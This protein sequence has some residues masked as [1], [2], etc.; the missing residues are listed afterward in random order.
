MKWR[1]RFRKIIKE[2]YRIDEVWYPI[3]H[4]QLYTRFSWGKRTWVEIAH[5]SMDRWKREKDYLENYFI[6]SSICNMFDKI[7]EIMND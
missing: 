3:L 4:I 2:N 6:N 5:H 7:R 1:R